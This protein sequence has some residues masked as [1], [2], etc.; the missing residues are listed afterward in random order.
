MIRA[1]FSKIQNRAYVIHSEKRRDRRRLI[2]TWTDAEGVKVNLFPAIMMADGREGCAASH[3]QLAKL[4]KQQGADGYHLI[5]EDDVVPRQIPYENLAQLFEAMDSN[6]FDVIWLGNL[7]MPW[8]RNTQWHSIQSGSAWSTYAILVN[9]RA[10]DFLSQFKWSGTPI[11]VELARAPLRGA[12]VHPE[13]FAQAR[14]PSN[15]RSTALSRLDAFGDL[16]QLYMPVWRKVV[17]YK[18]A[19]AILMIAVLV[20]VLLQW[21]L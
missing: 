20:V 19:L 3:T 10:L 18:Q 21:N 17:Y 1:L 7:P 2:D 15:V 12:W 8:S 4:L 5:L 13:F 9:Q 11:D 16:M 14:G 6:Q